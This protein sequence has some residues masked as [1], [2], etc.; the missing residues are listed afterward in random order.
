MQNLQCPAK[1]TSRDLLRALSV[2]F[3][4]AILLRLR[5]ECG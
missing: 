5:R 1:L 3:L 2:A 4:L